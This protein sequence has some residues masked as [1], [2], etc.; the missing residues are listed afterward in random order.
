MY[1][2]SVQTVSEQSENVETEEIL[3]ETVQNE[4]GAE[5]EKV[6]ESVDLA[7]VQAVVRESSNVDLSAAVPLAFADAYASSVVAQEGYDNSSL[8]AISGI[9][10]KLPGRKAWMEMVRANIWNFI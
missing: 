8:V 3:P 4:I 10:W 6:P 9:C 7:S 2:K 1:R 5:T